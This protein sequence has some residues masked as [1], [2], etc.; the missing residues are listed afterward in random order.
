MKDRG[1][2]NE[3]DDVMDTIFGVAKDVGADVAAMF[4]GLGPVGIKLPA[5]VISSMW[6]VAD[7]YVETNDDESKVYNVRLALAGFSKDDLKLSFED[8]YLTL[9]VKPSTI[10]D[11]PLASS[12]TH[13]L[14]RRIK[15]ASEAFKA[16]YFIDPEFFDKDKISSTFADG[17]LHIKV[18][19]L[20]K[21]EKPV[22]KK[23]IDIG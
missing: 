7:V 9:E 2:W 14:Q 5:G 3:F 11:A 21:V 13:W 1:V 17:L 23:D 8:D 10:L 19:S 6:P 22:T 18:T 16:S 20:P 12:K 4:E 15:N